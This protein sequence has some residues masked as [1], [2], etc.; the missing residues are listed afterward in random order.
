[1]VPLT[2]ACSAGD[3]ANLDDRV[4]SHVIEVTTKDFGFEMPEDIAT[5]WTT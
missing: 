2:V 3:Q 5:G 1:M 4:A